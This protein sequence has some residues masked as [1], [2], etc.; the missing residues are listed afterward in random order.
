VLLDRRNVPR[1]KLAVE[2]RLHALGA[3]ML[4]RKSVGH[5]D[6]PGSFG[7]RARPVIH[8]A[9][10]MSNTPSFKKRAFEDLDI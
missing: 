8:S 7:S 3:Q 2:E 4:V 6:T 10:R 9:L 1:G 5:R